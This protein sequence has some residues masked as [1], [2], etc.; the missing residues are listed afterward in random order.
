MCLA[1]GPQRSDACEART[2]SLSVSSQALSHC[3]PS[4]FE[5]LNLRRSIVYIKGSQD[6]ISEQKYISLDTEDILS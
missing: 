2:R 3:A 1:Q 4:W 6:I 5:T